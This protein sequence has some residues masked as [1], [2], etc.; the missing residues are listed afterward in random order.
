MLESLQKKLN[1]SLRIHTEFLLSDE[2]NIELTPIQTIWEVPTKYSVQQ[3][4]IF[5]YEGDH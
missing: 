1:L 5:I 3:V 2:F 4:R